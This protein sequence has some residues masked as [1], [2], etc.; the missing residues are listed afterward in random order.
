MASRIPPTPA[1]GGA[2]DRWLTRRDRKLRYR[3]VVKNDRW[4]HHRVAALNLRR[5]FTMGLIHTGT[6]GA[7]A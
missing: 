6:T 3:G 7:L 1:H 5:L 4:L 2:L